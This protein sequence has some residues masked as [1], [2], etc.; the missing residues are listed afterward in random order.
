MQRLPSVAAG[1][2]VRGT[3]HDPD[4]RLPASVAVSMAGIAGA[5]VLQL[6]WPQELVQTAVECQ[7]LGGLN[8]HCRHHLRRWLL[9]V[10]RQKADRS[11]RRATPET[12][13]EWL[14]PGNH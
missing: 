1:S 4:I 8:S 11:K 9:R 10:V 12:L 6:G 3:W 5:A 7:L 14:Q 2:W 13:W